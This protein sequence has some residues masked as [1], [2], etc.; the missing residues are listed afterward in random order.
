MRQS[1]KIKQVKD[2]VL[3]Y[4]NVMLTALRIQLEELKR[5][6]SDSGALVGLGNNRYNLI[7]ACV[8]THIQGGRKLHS[9]PST[10][11]MPGSNKKKRFVSLTDGWF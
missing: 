11:H 1:L 3:H 2:F 5:A 9:K 6:G 8:G 7:I 10:L 4:T